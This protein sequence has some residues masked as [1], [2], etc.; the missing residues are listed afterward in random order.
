MLLEF[1]FGI[2]IQVLDS[3]GV[4]GERERAYCWIAGVYVCV[5]VWVEY[6]AIRDTFLVCVNAE[7]CASVFA[8]EALSA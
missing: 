8:Y 7:L 1:R 4:D 2:G 5:C 3:N 6:V